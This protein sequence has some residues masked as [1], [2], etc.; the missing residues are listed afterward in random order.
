MLSPLICSRASLSMK[1]LCETSARIHTSTQIQRCI[2]GIQKNVAVAGLLASL[3]MVPLP[4]QL[5]CSKSEK[6]VKKAEA[7][8]ASRSAYAGLTA[9]VTADIKAK[10]CRT[11]TLRTVGV[12]RYSLRVFLRDQH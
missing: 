11:A 8:S 9:T 3:H 5:Q 6:S 12:L 4:R 7:I 1:G 2:E 10:S